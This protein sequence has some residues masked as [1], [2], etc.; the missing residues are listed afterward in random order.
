[1]KLSQEE[2]YYLYVESKIC[3]KWT[4][5]K[6]TETN[7]QTE[8]TDLW[9]PK[10]SGLEGEKDQSLELAEANYYIYRIDKQQGPI[11]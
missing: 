8:R 2:K 6:K 11:V 3:Y 1:M 4:Y 10:G 5:L 7:L 9:L